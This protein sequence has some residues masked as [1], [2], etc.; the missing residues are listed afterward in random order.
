M[1]SSSFSRPRHPSIYAFTTPLYRFAE[2]KGDKTGTGLIKIGYT[3]RDVSERVK[4]QFS[5]V[6]PDENPFEI[7]HFESAIKSDNTT[8][9]DSEVHRRLKN[10][11][12]RQ[13]RNEWFECTVDDLKQVITEIKRQET[14]ETRGRHR[15]YKMRPEQERA[16]TLTADYFNSVQAEEPDVASHFLWNAKMRFGKTFAT[17]KLA[18]KMK[19]NR[20][21]VLTYKPAVE[22]A[23]KEDLLGHVDF[24]GWQFIGPNDDYSGADEQRPIVWFA[25]FQDILGRTREGRIKPKF[26]VAHLIEW[27]CVVLDEYH[28]GAWRESAKELYDAEN[29]KEFASSIG[30]EF[31]PET[32]PL[33]VRQY[34]YL[35][36]TPFRIL[37]SGEFLE[38]QIYNW[39]YADEQRAKLAWDDSS[40]AYNPYVELPTMKMLTYELPEE[41]RDIALQGV[42]NEFDLNEFFSAKINDDTGECEF[43]Y[44]DEIQSWLD[45][46]R[47]AYFGKNATT[48]GLPGDPPLPFKDV[49]LK[50][51]LRHSFWF[52]PSVASCR[53]MANLLSKSSNSFYHDYRVIVA[54]GESAGVGV[55]ALEPV[56]DAIGQGITTK[57]ITLSCGKLTTGVTVPPWTGIFILRNTTSPETYF[58][59][60]FRVQSPWYS[61][62]PS[63]D[64][65]ED[66]IIHKSECYVFDFSPSRALT[67]IAEYTS[68]FDNN[69]E[70]AQIEE[71]TGEFLEFLPVLCYDGYGMRE[72]DATSLLDYMATG[73]SATMIAKR[74]QSSQLLN[75]G[76]AILSDIAGRQEVLDIMGKITAF[77]NLNRD[78]T[79]VLSSERSLKK[80]K[81][82]RGKPVTPQE[83]VQERENQKFRRT[84][85][86]KLLK[87]LT[88]IP[89]FM[90]MTDYR[91][92]SLT[93]VIFNVEP[94]LFE[95]VTGITV[96]DFKQ[97]CEVGVFK[98]REMNSA[99]FAFKRFEESSL[100]YASTQTTRSKSVG[101]FDT[102]ISRDEFEAEY[103]DD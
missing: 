43:T 20:V 91:E 49:Y 69:N 26:E 5:S 33:N 2:W 54:A 15:T 94:E 75:I 102:I 16:V 99:I 80:T 3:E 87:F 70:V 47:G 40:D 6:S 27:D 71:R 68:K 83:R 11:G 103:P 35:S 21:L 85:R 10:K 67:L 96:E 32:F 65:P 81:R 61:D 28:Y 84:L 36:G 73:T 72:L 17:Y 62:N 8:F 100:N 34:L 79:R 37:A 59:A 24:D 76:D 66:K 53:A 77:R 93:D 30:Q 52:L 29:K 55:K 86:E 58:Q 23:W 14:Y 13:V 57:S 78:I 31:D 89:L 22:E 98:S 56:Q 88:R 42:Q 97:L 19:W 38:N 64:A 63:G 7:L 60:A 25:S 41:I 46:I 51:T 1:D 44:E 9:R 90:Y 45:V 92:R 18:Q 95:E 50:S 4:E 82:E 39:S 74:W 12:F 101:G 48:V